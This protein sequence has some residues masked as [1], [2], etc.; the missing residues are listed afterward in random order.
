MGRP[1]RIPER[2]DVPPVSAAARLGL[3]LAE[4]EARLEDLASRGFPDADE[5]TGHYCLEAVD[6]WRL[7]RHAKLFPELM[8]LPT[9][10]D[11]STVFAERM[12]RLSGAG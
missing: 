8:H 3:S 11:A 12:G 9:A 2:G 7:R 10:R 1:K 6:R 4:F 5:T